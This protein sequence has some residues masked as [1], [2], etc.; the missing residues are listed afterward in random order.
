M[1][2]DAAA[3][4]TFGTARV[5]LDHYGYSFSGIPIRSYD[6]HPDGLR[7][8]ATGDIFGGKPLLRTAIPEAFRQALETF[9]SKDLA[10]FDYW[11]RSDPQ[12]RLSPSLERRLRESS[13]VQINI[14]QNWFEELKRLVPA[15]KKWRGLQ[16]PG[17]L[18]G[19]LCALVF[20][21]TRIGYAFWFRFSE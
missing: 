18:L 5:L 15:G 20:P 13:T 1:V 6:L 3:D 4:P 7:F 14:F 16:D 17:S 11:L 9:D 2:V 21:A 8:P 12:R 10:R 19:W